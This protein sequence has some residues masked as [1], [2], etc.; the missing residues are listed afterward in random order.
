MSRRPP[1]TA[2]LNG[3]AVKIAFGSMR[4]TSNPGSARRS[5]RAQAAPA[6]PPPTTTM[7]ALP[8][9]K[10]GDGSST[11]EAA[12]ALPLRNPLRVGRITAWASVLHRK[13]GGNCA[14]LFVREAL[15]EA[16]HYRRR[17]LAGAES[18]HCR[19]DRGWVAAA[20]RRNRALHLGARRV[21]TRAR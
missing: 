5:V 17:A 16:A 7:R 1:M 4:V 13:P 11:A 6:N 2:L 8:C 15:G 18:Q 20:D 19:D 21:T 14:G 3:H 12:A 9:A 10:A